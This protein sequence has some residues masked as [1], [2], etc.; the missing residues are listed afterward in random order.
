MSF[1]KPIFLGI[2]AAFFAL[3]LEI[4]FSIVS[5]L[6]AL[7]YLTAGMS[8]TL[9]FSAFAEELAKYSVIYKSFSSLKS[10]VQIISSGLIVGLGFAA[11][12]LYFNY[13]NKGAVIFSPLGPWREF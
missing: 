1:I 13:Y 9:V 12:E 11:V 2:L 4:S 7:G 8:I 3:V 10:R 6:G 5:G